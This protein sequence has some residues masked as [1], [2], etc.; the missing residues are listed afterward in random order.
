MLIIYTVIYADRYNIGKWNVT[1]QFLN[2]LPADA[3]TLGNHEFDHGVEGVVPFMEHLNS[4]V[5]ITNVND[6][7]EPTIQKKYTNSVII[8]KYE[9]KI[10]VIGVILRSTNTIARTGGLTFYPEPE[11]V[12]EEAAKLKEQGVKIIVVLSHCGLQ[13][14][15]EIARFGGNDIDIIIGGHSHSFLFSGTEYPALDI[16][17]DTYPVVETQENGH[18]VLIVQASAFTKYVG[19][20]T[21]YFDQDGIIQNWEGEPIYLSADVPQDPDVLEAMK[22]WRELVDASGKRVVGEFKFDVSGFGCYQGECL[23]GSLIADAMAYSVIDTENDDDG[24]TYA[25]IAITNPGGIRAGLAR[26]VA[27]FSD[28]VTTTPFENTIDSMEL[29]GKYIRE[30]LEFS[31]RYTSPSILQTSGIKVVFDMSKPAYQRIVSLKVLCRLCDIPQYEEIDNEAW[32]G[33]V[34]NNFLL[35]NGDNFAMIRDNSLNH[36]VGGVDIDVLTAYVEK[37]SPITSISPLGRVTFV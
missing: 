16:P 25:T 9:M 28:L 12:R 8:D 15:Q 37:F 31:V 7:L 22:P 20:I 10:G 18:R 23:M 34:V 3:I 19:D 35:Q 24:W 5:V 6:S 29:Q 36:K 30:A 27:T 11:A 2:M 32:Y 17:V 14:D 33:I 26:G 4:P 13:R 1:S 21:L